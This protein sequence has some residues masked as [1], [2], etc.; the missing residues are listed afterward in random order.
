MLC[1][2]SNLKIAHKLTL[3]FGLVLLLM[4]ATLVTDVLASRQQTNVVDQ[5][6]DRLYPSRQAAN[7]IVSLV[8]AAN[9]ARL[10]YVLTANEHDAAAQLQ[11]YNQD[12]QQ[13]RALLGQARALAS[14]DAQRTIADAFSPVFFG[15]GG[16]YDD[17]HHAITLKQEGK[18]AA[19]YTEVTD[20]DPSVASLQIAHK[21]IN[22]VEQDIAQQTAQEEQLSR[23]VLVL[24]LSLGM[25]AVCLG[26]GIALIIIRSIA[27][28]LAEVQ[29]AAQQLCRTDVANLASGL[30]A[31]AR[32]DLTVTAQTGSIAPL[33]HSRDE[34][35]QTAQ[36]MRSIVADVQRTVDGYEVA[37]LELQ[38]LYGQ[39]AEQN[40][41]LQ[42]LS[43]TDP[44]TGLPNH[45]T[46]MSRVEEELSRC[47]RTQASCAL[48]FVDLDHFKRIND[49]WRHQAGDAILREAGR[50]LSSCLR[51]EDFVGRYGGEEFA[52]VLAHTEQ[53][54]AH[55]VA[56]RIRAALAE[57]P[58]LWQ[59]EEVSS[60]VAIPIT[61]SIGVA[62]FQEHGSSRETL[63]EAADN[64]MYFAKH[65][66]RNRICLAGEEM[67]VVQEVLAKTRDGQM[68]DGIAV[69]A[70]G[71]AAHVHDRGSASRRNTC[72]TSLSASTGPTRRAGPQAAAAAA[73]AG[74]GSPL[75]SGSS[76]P[77]AGRLRSRAG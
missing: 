48:L 11:T 61:A 76:M 46:V 2:F 36:A 51:L 70:L 54:E 53:G 62:V 34:I 29:H 1:W 15:K 25:L 39:L 22:V 73:A 14:S 49:T 42:S 33:Y 37:R 18:L 59:A 45:R 43:T 27:R 6:V 28:P 57:T 47:R 26:S 21:Y 44:L 38:Q 58:C 7:E 24:S 19:A 63:L 60:A 4:T 9:N 52:I 67:A 65:T 32:G 31:L 40:K 13:L 3:G 50:R 56:E 20:D 35:G 55:Q 16:F 77:M 12:M 74:L 10:V 8:Y 23:L 68:S 30:L 69:Q 64:A 66:G 5:L 75:S 41:T 71:A 72:R 17:T